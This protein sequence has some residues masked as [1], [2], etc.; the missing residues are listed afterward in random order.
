MENRESRRR[1]ARRHLHRAHELLESHAFGSNAEY[2]KPRENDF[3][4]ILTDWLKWSD[5]FKWSRKK[6]DTEDR[7]SSL[8]HELKMELFSHLD[9]ETAEVL[10]R[11]N[12]GY[13]EAGRGY[14]EREAKKRANEPGALLEAVKNDKTIMVDLLLKEGCET[15]SKMLKLAVKNGNL[16]IVNLL[17]DNGEAKKIHGNRYWRLLVGL[18]IY[19]TEE[20]KGPHLSVLESLLEKGVDHAPGD[21]D[22]AFDAFIIQTEIWMD[23]EQPLHR[24]LGILKMFMSKGAKCGVYGTIETCVQRGDKPYIAIAELLDSHPEK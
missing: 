7:M 22:H 19:G 21:L 3:G 8:R 24:L 20:R 5:W 9:D 18:A 16:E 10:R 2:D 4:G 23:P 14:Y 17:L 12:S 11:A 13:R 6:P 1:R 15:D